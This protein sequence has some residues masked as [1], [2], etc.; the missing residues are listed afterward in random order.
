MKLLS[1]PKKKVRWNLFILAHLDEEAPKELLV[2]ENKYFYLAF[3]Y[4]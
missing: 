4:A 1:V 3:I 2:S